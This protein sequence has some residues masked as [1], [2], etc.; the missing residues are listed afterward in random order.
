MKSA[1]RLT[2]PEFSAAMALR[3]AIPFL[4]GLMLVALLK[5]NY[6]TLAT[7]MIEVEVPEEALIAMGLT[8]LNGTELTLT[9]RGEKV[10]VFFLNL[11]GDAIGQMH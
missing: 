3:K 5:G 10:A 9:A 11:I 1:V 2:G 6:E 7:M 8:E 4:H